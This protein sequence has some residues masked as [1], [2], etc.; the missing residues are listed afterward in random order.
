MGPLFTKILADQFQRL[1]DGDRFFYLNEQWNA[2]EI[3]FLLQGD[4]LG[5]VI[6]ANTGITNLQRDVF[7]FT[8]SIS[9]QVSLQGKGS[10]S[11]QGV[12]G[13]TVELTNDNGDVLAT[14]TTDRFGRYTFNQLSGPAANPETGSGVSATGD[15]HVV[16]VLPPNLVQLGPKPGTITITRGATNVTNVNFTVNA[17]TSQAAAS[18]LQAPGTS[19]LA[20]VGA[21][22]AGGTATGGV[23]PAAVDALVQTLAPSM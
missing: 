2:D 12:P 3:K 6:T 21:A 4:T 5:K 14:T 16:L 13:V 19:S 17:K 8:A 20:L 10:T 22:D 11:G 23:D 18:A 15:Y 9:G 7:K 1:R